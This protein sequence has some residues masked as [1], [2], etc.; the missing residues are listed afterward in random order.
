MV[1]DFLIYYGNISSSQKDEE[2][3]LKEV[4][5]LRGRFLHWTSIIERIMNE[6]CNESKKTYGKI[7][8][9]FIQK[10]T[11]S[12]LSHKDNFFEFVK[13][14]NEINPDRNAWA[15]GFIFYNEREGSNPNNFLNLNNKLT[16]VKPPY[17]EE[18]SKSFSLIIDWLSKN[19]LW[20]IDSYAIS[21][22]KR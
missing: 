5:I 20:K 22:F 7:K 21:S 4:H 6:Y 16:S 10:L 8:D 1:D 15:H 11:A 19:N 17:F 9:S 12:E 13:A 18:I 3:D 14:L 2:N